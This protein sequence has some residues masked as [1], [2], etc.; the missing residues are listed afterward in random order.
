PLGRRGCHGAAWLAG[1]GRGAVRAG[2]N[3]HVPQ[4]EADTSVLRYGACAVL[5]CRSAAATGAHRGGG[6]NG[7]C[8][9]LAGAAGP[10]FPQPSASGSRLSPRTGRPTV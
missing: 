10:P 6:G 9:E 1:L 8:A 2:C 4:G 5:R 3:G 7:G